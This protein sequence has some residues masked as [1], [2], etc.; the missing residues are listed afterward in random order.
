MIKLFA[1]IVIFPL[2]THTRI[3]LFNFLLMPIP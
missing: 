3:A 2:D 1:A